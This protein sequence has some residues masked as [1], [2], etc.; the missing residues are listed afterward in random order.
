MCPQEPLSMVLDTLLV[1]S[2]PL[3]PFA[4][5]HL[6]LRFS[7]VVIFNFDEKVMIFLHHPGKI[8]L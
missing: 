3:L 6:V 8:E 1:I 5:P 4:Q 7:F 2:Q